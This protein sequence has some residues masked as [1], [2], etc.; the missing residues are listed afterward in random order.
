MTFSDLRQ[1]QHDHAFGQQQRKPGELRTVI[2][3]VMTSSMM[4]VEI[5]AGVAFGSMALLADGL[6]MASH[7]AALSIA[8]FAY[9]YTRRNARDRRFSFGTGKVNALGG[10]AGAILL[11]VF[12]LMM[13]GESV[14][15]LMHPVHIAFNQ[16]LLVAFVGL[17]V[18]GVSVLILDHRGHDGDEDTH[19]ET[20]DGNCQ[21]QHDHNLRAAYLHVLADAL[22]SVLAIFALLAGKYL[23]LTWTDPLMGIVGALLVGRWSLGL[24]QTTGSVLLD[25]Q[26]PESLEGAIRHS[27]EQ[28]ADNRVADLHVWSIGPAIYAVEVAVVSADPQPPET[29][30]KM[31]PA[32]KGL[33][34][35]TV[36]VHRDVQNA[37]DL[38][39][40]GV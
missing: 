36:E 24:L 20:H 28:H 17:A 19:H 32:G 3:I 11:A 37:E 40:E 21:H 26:G 1:W 12:A 18:N 34:H 6:H 23:A 31:L 29:Y 13:V 10:F 22:T 14:D 33:V 4:I 15:R 16:A 35:V 25:R 38:E 8:A 30:R 7:A 27:I 2:V 39:T 5:A 9:I